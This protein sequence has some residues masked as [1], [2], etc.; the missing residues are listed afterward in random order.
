MKCQ[1]C[2]K[3]ANP[4]MMSFFNEDMICAKCETLEKAHPK[5]KEAKAAEMAEVRKGNYNFK[6]IGKPHDL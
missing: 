1:R 3:D 5:Y 4:Q 6:G 2:N